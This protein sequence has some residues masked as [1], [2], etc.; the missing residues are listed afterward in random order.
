MLNIVS[1]GLGNQSSYMLIRALSGDYDFYP[2]YAV[3]SDT[4]CEP[5]YTYKYLEYLQ[6]YCQKYFNFEITVIKPPSILQDYTDYLSGNRSSYISL[7]FFTGIGNGILHRQCSLH[8]KIRP[9]RRFIQSVRKG[10]PVALHLGISADEAHRMSDSNVKY[11]QHF[12]PLITSGI[13]LSHILNYFKTSSI[14][15]PYKSACIICPFHSNKF[16]LFL[17]ENE[18]VNF[19][20]ACSFD[21]SIRNISSGNF[22]Y[23]L[24]RSCMPL[25]QVNLFK[26]PSLFKDL[27][28]PA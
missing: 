24:H 14:K 25:G 22:E 9:I 10:K 19:N 21:N 28:Y 1:L 15:V 6:F 16:W 27:S 20:V 3:F 2:D 12:F 13:F 8:Y 4:G 7:P 17:K 26:H 5:A 11:I 23:F 18:P